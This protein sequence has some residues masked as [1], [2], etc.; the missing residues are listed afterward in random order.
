MFIH[1]VILLC[2]NQNPD[3]GYVREFFPQIQAIVNPL[4]TE[5]IEPVPSMGI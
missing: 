3:I 2:I 5:L 4:S 1:D